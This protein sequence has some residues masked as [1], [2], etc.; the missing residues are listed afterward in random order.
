[1]LTVSLLG[2]IVLAWLQSFERVSTTPASSND[3]KGGRNDAFVNCRFACQWP[4]AIRCTCKPYAAG[5]QDLQV[6]HPFSSL[7]RSFFAPQVWQAGVPM[8]VHVDF[9]V[10]DSSAAKV[11]A[12]NTMQK[13]QPH[14]WQALEKLQSASA[15]E[16]QLE[17]AAD[18][19]RAALRGHGRP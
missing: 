14:A 5:K 11:W 13:A 17:E 12:V 4:G 2:P 7:P 16:Q 6:D 8:E 9:D 3:V 15:I 1:M 19:T 18:K 10:P